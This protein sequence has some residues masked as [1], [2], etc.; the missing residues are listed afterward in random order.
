MEPLIISKRNKKIRITTVLIHRHNTQGLQRWQKSCVLMHMLL[1]HRRTPWPSGSLS[2]LG[3]RAVGLRPSGV[4]FLL[5]FFSVS[6]SFDSWNNPWGRKE[7]R[8]SPV[9]VNKPFMLT[10]MSGKGRLHVSLVYLLCLL[11][12]FSYLPL[13]RGRRQWKTLSSFVNWK[14]KCI[15][16]LEI[17][18]TEIF[19]FQKRMIKW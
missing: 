13:G 14:A 17:V 8:P 5:N 6:L 1:A 16:F 7:G 11:S 19:V 9:Q 3:L 12:K 10:Q 4:T 2:K 18:H 15:Y